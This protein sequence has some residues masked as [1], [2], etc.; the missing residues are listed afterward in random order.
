MT[1]WAEY[2]HTSTNLICQ[3]YLRLFVFELE[4]RE[5]TD[6]KDKQTGKIRNVAY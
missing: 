6:G 5:K 3:P 2:R 4:A 1:F